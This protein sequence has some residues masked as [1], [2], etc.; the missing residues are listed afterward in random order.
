MSICYPVSKPVLAGNEARY[1]TEAV[2]STWISSTGKFVSNFEEKVS[3]FVGVESG[4]SV[5]N[6][7]VGLHLACLAL[8][9]RA[10]DEVIMPSLTY[11]AS[12]NSVAY[13]GATPVFVDCDPHTW[14]MTKETLAAAVTSRTVGVMAVHLYGL[15]S[16]MPEIMDFCRSRGLWL[17]EDCAESLGASINGKMTGSFGDAAVF[18]F[19]GNKTISTGEGGMVLVAD[20]KKR[21]FARLL[22][23]Q[24]MDPQH[25]YWHAIIGYNYRMTNVAAAIGCGQMEMADYHLS[26]RRRVA[27]TYAR[28]LLP[29]A[30]DGTIAFQAQPA[31]YQSSYWL[32]SIVLSCLDANDDIARAQRERIMQYLAET[33]G[34]ETRP[35]FYSCH[36]LPMYAGGTRLLPHSEYLSARGINLPSYSGLAD[37]DIEKISIAII[38]CLQN[39]DCWRV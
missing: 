33:S 24:G 36:S 32:S 20:A 13:C 4:I 1:V 2:E 6:G 30:Q 21:D 23:G 29:L 27:K 19:Y 10:G 38:E 14:S 39:I 3:G 7:T 11:I 12:A 15:P 22:R 17:I 26:E 35:F 37:E 9:L 18:S 5:S 16:P 8:G 28:N 34:V 25:R 31:G